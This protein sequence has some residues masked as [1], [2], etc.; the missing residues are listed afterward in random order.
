M[1]GGASAYAVDTTIPAGGMITLGADLVLEGT[2]SFV[3]GGPGGARCRIDGQGHGIATM[4][5][6][7]GTISINGCDIVNLGTVMQPAIDVHSATVPMFDVEGSTFDLS[8]KISI[9]ASGDLPIVFRGNTLTATS[10]VNVEKDS[11][12][13][14]DPAFDLE[15]AGKVAKVFQGNKVL[16]SWVRMI[17]TDNWLI[18]GD[19]PADGNLLV[20]TRGGLELRGED[21]TV[22]GNYLG[23]NG[24]L[25]GWN[26]VA[27]LNATSDNATIVIEHNIIRGG[28][29]LIRSLEG[30]E[31]RYNILGDPGVIA[32]AQTGSATH[33]KVHH[34]VMVRNNKLM[35]NYQYV[36]GIQVIIPPRGDPPDLEIYN[37]TMDGSGSCY[38]PMAR[39]VSVD[40]QSILHSLRSNAIFNMPTQVPGPNGVDN[41]AMIGPGQDMMFKA[42]LKGD[43]G[44]AAMEYADYNLFFNPMAK[45]IDNY[46]ISV[47]GFTERISAGFA[48]ND[49]QAGGAK[50]QQ[51]DPQLTGPLPKVFPFPEDDIIAGKYN[52]CQILAFYRG[53]YTPAPG[54]PLIDA[55]DPADG[56]GND[57]GAVGAGAPH[58]ADLFGT[59]C[60]PA[61]SALALAPVVETKCP[62]PIK[63]AVG[64]AIPVGGGGG[65]PTTGPREIVCVC[66]ESATVLRGEGAALMGVLAA[67]AFG[68]RPSKRRRRSATP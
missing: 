68:L 36:T 24:E 63:E 62:T 31:L 6:W 58:P 19:T 67:L 15:G 48:R 18:G 26:Q 11:V 66:D 60:S 44:P 1:G 61:D 22:R 2:D 50:D 10:V 56:A 47:A 9:I 41:T 17:N 12:D 52:V 49:A 4:M 40:D 46:G 34:N 20:G 39:A 28:N 25:D 51:V 57:I 35:Q 38:D 45:A 64:G 30:S 54:S 14:S 23:A 16:R 65:P 42:V 13:H 29:W 3:A 7:K 59:L 43:P 21:I 53:L 32:W 27:V 55:G 33:T 5:D 8:G 37:N